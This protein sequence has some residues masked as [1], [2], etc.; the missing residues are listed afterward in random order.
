MVEVVPLPGLKAR[1]AILSRCF[2]NLIENGTID[3]S[4]PFTPILIPAEVACSRDSE[5]LHSAYTRLPTLEDP[6]EAIVEPL[7]GFIS[8][9]FML[10]LGKKGFSTQ[11]LLL[12]MQCQG[13]CGRTLTQVPHSALMF[14]GQ[15][16]CAAHGAVLVVRRALLKAIADG[17]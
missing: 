6:D 13:L 8:A 1:Y 16:G 9:K 17:R 4:I 2:R 11:V 3:P 7:P 14:E 12:A 5:T 15:H 10:L